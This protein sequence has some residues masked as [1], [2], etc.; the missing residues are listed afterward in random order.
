M[1]HAKSNKGEKKCKESCEKPQR[2]NRLEVKKLKACEAKIKNSNIDNLNVRS[3]N[4]VPTS[5]CTQLSGNV[6]S[7][8]EQIQYGPDGPIQ[9]TNP[10]NF[11]QEAWDAAWAELNCQAYFPNQYPAFTGSF[12]VTGTI[13][14][15][16]SLVPN[17]GLLGEG[18]VVTVLPSGN[19]LGT[20][21]SQISGETGAVGDYNFVASNVLPVGEK[22]LQSF[23]E[24]GIQE[25]LKCGR[26]QIRL[27]NNFYGCKTCP[28]PT[29]AGCYPFCPEGTPTFNGEFNLDGTEL[30]VN[31][32][33]PGTGLLSEGSPV[34]DL[35]TRENFGTL[36]SQIS[37]TT[38]GVGVYN[39]NLET[40]SLPV[41]A[42]DLQ[43]LSEVCECPTEEGDCPDVG[44]NI[45]GVK[46]LPPRFFTSCGPTGATGATGAFEN[47]QFL[48]GMAFNLSVKNLTSNLGT[49]VVY[50]LSLVSYIDE[51]GAVQSKIIDIQAKQ[52]GPTIDT[53]I[54]ENYTGTIPL[55]TNFMQ[56]LVNLMPDRNNAPVIEMVVYAEDGLDIV[57]N[58]EFPTCV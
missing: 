9:P 52:F 42:L 57:V 32:I 44:L 11:N 45:W 28:P 39:F 46:A 17:T 35:N 56:E 49:R 30:T 24:G 55:S 58:P 51:L 34:V 10:G 15:V 18:S 5:N 29:L 3:I 36:G 12:D 54:G 22:D 7:A 27:I 31:S 6:V 38:G 40:L 16:S 19:V 13:L 14:T 48:S 33:V 53:L 20:I 4:G 21:T 1:G 47:V 37:G 25:R 41:G 26:L 43:S 8:F 2:F 23:N 50:V